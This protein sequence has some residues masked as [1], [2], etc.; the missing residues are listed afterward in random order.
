MD[1]F[2]QIISTRKLSFIYILI[3]AAF[4]LTISNID[5]LQ[6]LV[7]NYE[8]LSIAY[9]F[10]ASYENCVILLRSLLLILGLIIIGKNTI[11]FFM[12]PF[13]EISFAIGAGIFS[14]LLFFIGMCGF[15]TEKI[16]LSVY[17]LV[18]LIILFDLKFLAQSY[19]NQ[20][21]QLFRKYNLF[22]IIIIG[23]IV[24]IFIQGI[25]VALAPQV[26]WDSVASQLALPKIFLQN[27]NIKPILYILH[28]SW[29]LASE[30]IYGVFLIFG[31]GSEAGIFQL[32]YGFCSVLLV[33]RIARRVLPHSAALLAC[34]VFSST[35]IFSTLLPVAK[36]DFAVAVY[37]LLAFYFFISS[38]DDNSP[39]SIFL[40]G[41]LLGFA[42]SVKLTG[43]VLIFIM[44]LA[45]IL[46]HFN[47]YRNLIRSIVTIFLGSFCVVL[48]WLVRSW[49]Y[50]GNPVWPFCSIL[51]SKTHLYYEHRHFFAGFGKLEP[52]ETIIESIFKFPLRLFGYFDG[53]PMQTSVL[54]FALFFIIVIAGTLSLKK[55]KWFIFFP[56]F[57]CVFFFYHSGFWR[58]FLPMFALLS[59]VT[60]G[61]IYKAATRKTLRSYLILCVALLFFIPKPGI[62]PKD[63]FLTFIGLTPNDPTL[64][65]RQRYKQLHLNSFRLME[66]I[67]TNLPP[68]AKILLFREVRGFYLDREYMWSMPLNQ[69]LICFDE[70]ES[71]GGFD[72]ITKLGI[73]H[74]LYNRKIM[75]RY[76]IIPTIILEKELPRHARCIKQI[77]DVELWEILPITS[78]RIKGKNR[79]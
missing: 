46:T 4:F 36:N 7:H 14:L 49:I 60:S 71:Y 40:C 58:Y 18:I 26:N 2:R 59:I 6:Y 31:E 45:I 33:Y 5:L 39:R 15:Y 10:L 34:A 22:E 41:I 52:N 79:T 55:Y 37:F 57:F 53:F 29:P 70:W 69:R 48:P 27:S 38:T 43:F 75:S 9:F 64:T 32:F 24:S 30:L 20:K 68:D 19:I 76:E 56:V 65:P 61:Y 78:K 25:I 13:F 23:F 54:F 28:S 66:W 12:N 74:I 51:F 63:A 62:F 77:D 35:D 67:N 3:P 42:M 44:L 72:Q 17:V 8:R 16:L 50:R 21:N 73:T 1:L 47:N 11:R